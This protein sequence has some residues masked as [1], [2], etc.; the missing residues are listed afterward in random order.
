[1]AAN[2]TELRGY[3]P[4]DMQLSVFSNS[5]AE[6][7]RS[8]FIEAIAGQLATDEFIDELQTRHLVRLEAKEPSEASS[9]ISTEVSR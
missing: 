2:S 7:A 1:V 6:R 3:A 9:S 8:G 5:L 4:L